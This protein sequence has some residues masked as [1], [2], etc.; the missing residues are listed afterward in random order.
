MLSIELGGGFIAGLSARNLYNFSTSISQWS[1]HQFGAISASTLAAVSDSATAEAIASIKTVQLAYLTREQHDQIQANKL[2]F[3]CEIEGS[4]LKIIKPPIGIN[5]PSLQFDGNGSS[6]SSPPSI[7]ELTDFSARGIAI[8]GSLLAGLIAASPSMFID[9]FKGGLSTAQRAL[10][11]Y[12]RTQIVLIR[13][14]VGLLSSIGTAANYFN[15]AS[16]GSADAT[17]LILQGVSNISSSAKCTTA[18]INALC[19]GESSSIVMRALLSVFGINSNTMYLI[20][21]AGGLEPI[22]KQMPLKTLN[23]EKA[24]TIYT[25]E[26]VSTSGFKPLFIQEIPIGASEDAIS[27][28]KANTLKKLDEN[29]SV[30]ASGDSTGARLQVAANT[31]ENSRNSIDFTGAKVL[32]DGLLAAY[33][34]Y[35]LTKEIQ[36]PDANH[37][38][39]AASIVE[40]VSGTLFGI[41]MVFSDIFGASAAGGSLSIA[42]KLTS[43][44]ER[45]GQA[46]TAVANLGTKA[47]A[48]GVLAGATGALTSQIIYTVDVNHD[49]NAS[50]ADKIASDVSAAYIGV[51]TVASIA[52]IV[53]PEF[54]PIVMV[55]SLLMP[56]FS[57][58]ASAVNL[59]AQ[60]A[61]ANSQGQYVYANYILQA[62]YNISALNATPIV[63]WFAAGYQK[64]IADQ[65]AITMSANDDALVWE[66]LKQYYE[67]QL[68][69]SAEGGAL[70]INTIAAINNSGLGYS[71]DAIFIVAH[72]TNAN[73]YGANDN[74]VLSYVTALNVS[75]LY[76]SAMTLNQA[77]SSQNISIAYGIGGMQ[78]SIS[79]TVSGDDAVS[80]TIDLS[81]FQ[82]TS[83]VDKMNTFEIQ[84]NN[85]AITGN[86]L[87]Q[88]YLDVGM[89]KDINTI[90]LSA[91]TL[92]TVNKTLYLED[93]TGAASGLNLNLDNFAS[94]AVKGLYSNNFSTSFITGALSGESYQY[95]GGQDKVSMLG[96]KG[97][98]TIGGAGS[99]LLM[100][101]GGNKASV[102]LDK[103]GL[104]S[105]TQSG[106]SMGS[107]D[108]GDATSINQNSIDFSMPLNDDLYFESDS[109]W[110]DVYA[111]ANLSNEFGS[112]YTTPSDAIDGGKFKNF[113]TVKVGA[114][115]NVLDVGNGTEIRSLTLAGQYTNRLNL[116][117][118]DPNSEFTVL[119]SDIL[120]SSSE[121]NLGNTSSKHL[122][123]SAQMGNLTV[124][125]GQFSGILNLETSYGFGSTTFSDKGKSGDQGIISV[126]ILDSY[127]TNTFNFYGN[128]TDLIVID[129]AK[130]SVTTINEFS[131][132]SRGTTLGITILGCDPAEIVY[133]F[134]ATN[135]LTQA[136][137]GHTF[138]TINFS[139]P[140]DMQSVRTHY[141][142]QPPGAWTA[143]QIS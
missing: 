42:T 67:Y 65:L 54:L 4:A 62:F 47:G 119:A 14:S 97:E 122:N 136:I 30:Y 121:I 116:E 39:N 11:S 110:T 44:A 141:G 98:V 46:K 28:L 123:I 85:V 115:N 114:N 111:F 8:F 142:N 45:L 84:K 108:G 48:I 17:E 73:N 103:N 95:G 9:F 70:I 59:R 58:I 87:T 86:S 104:S 130:R 79:A 66:A 101:G 27:A 31:V 128:T 138:L 91:T 129:S 113:S 75:S 132:R 112:G 29:Y 107:Y 93:V 35:T 133:S 80:V 127:D 131:V 18:I 7:P 51:L 13:G 124:N 68:I 52:A 20:D 37:N 63:N 126:N 100:G 134:S 72:Q 41:S 83:G 77:D 125:A 74:Q 89:V 105:Y 40:G 139:D 64:S 43:I 25:G 24:Y 21:G 118:T 22:N 106:Y 12:Q 33:S 92:S 55:G 88:Y 16:N 57:G 19:S 90:T 5:P 6:P 76:G 3:N 56:N 1:A 26:G 143:L 137:A 120:Y 102:K 99:T 81:K 117:L 2:I 61:V 53:A 94:Y 49:P 135:T 15:E 71:F 109:A 50:L 82:T 38:I 140:A 34:L 23:N 69:R 10:I 32:A 78:S 60:Q 96:G 36:A